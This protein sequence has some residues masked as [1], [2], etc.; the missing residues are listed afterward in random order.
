MCQAFA[1]SVLVVLPGVLAPG[2]KDRKKADKKDSIHVT[3]PKAGPKGGWV[4]GFGGTPSSGIKINSKR[5]R[6]GERR[7][8]IHSKQTD[9]HIKASRRGGKELNVKK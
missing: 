2:L 8:S 9:K 5:E 4:F 6:Q 1:C 3:S 7:A